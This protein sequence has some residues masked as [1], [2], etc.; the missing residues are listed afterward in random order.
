M[1]T[2]EVGVIAFAIAILAVLLIVLLAVPAYLML[3]YGVPG[4]TLADRWASARYVFDFDSHLEWL[5]VSSKQAKQHR[6]ELRANIADAASEGGMAAALERLGS[7]RALALAVAHDA[8]RPRWVRGGLVA[9]LAFVAIQWFYV[10]AADIAAESAGSAA[11]GATEVTVDT[12][13]L[14][15]LTVEVATDSTGELDAVSLEQDA[16]ALI[17]PVLIGLLAAQPWRARRRA[18][19]KA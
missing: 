7:P 15:G 9:M 10:G 5:G 2:A 19:V 4:V 16:R 13:L 12:A 17:A 11:S 6:A 18:T 3:G 14:P 8:R 1:I